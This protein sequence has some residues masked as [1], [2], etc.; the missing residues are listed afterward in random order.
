MSRQSRRRRRVRPTR[1]NWPARRRREVRRRRNR[2]FGIERF[3]PKIALTVTPTLVADINQTHL[4]GDPADFLIAGDVA[5]FTAFDPAHG[6]EL[7]KTD[8][9]SAGTSLVTDLTPGTASSGIAN[10]T[11]AGGKLF[12]TTSFN[13]DLWGPPTGK[14]LWTLDPATDTL[15]SLAEDVQTGYPGQAF[16]GILDDEFF[17]WRG[18]DQAATDDLWKT[19]G[20]VAGTSL[21]ASF[22]LAQAS[23]LQAAGGRLY[24]PAT[25]AELGEELYWTDGTGATLVKD[26]AAGEASSYADVLGVAGDTVLFRA[27]DGEIGTELWRTDPVEGAVLVA[28]LL[29]GSWS[30]NPFNLLVSGDQLF[31]LADDTDSQSRPRRIEDFLSSDPQVTTF[32]LEN[33]NEMLV[34][35]D[36]LYLA[37]DDGQVGNELWRVALN[38]GEPELVKNIFGPFVTEAFANVPGVPPITTETEPGNDSLA[39]AD[40]LRGSFVEVEPGVFEATVGLSAESDSSTDYFRFFLPA[41]YQLSIAAGTY[42]YADVY[43]A[44]GNSAGSMSYQPF[45]ASESGDYIVEVVTYSWLGAPESI[46]FRISV[47]D[48]GSFPGGFTAVGDTLYF[49]ANDREHGLEL[50][51]T[52]ATEGAVLVGDFYPGPGSSAPAGLTVVGTEVFFRANGNEIWKASEAAGAV[53]LATVGPENEEPLGSGSYAMFAVLDGK[54]LFADDDG[55]TG[56]ELW[57]TDTATGATGL[58]KEIA[59]GNEGAFGGSMS[60]GAAAALDGVLYF[61]ATDDTGTELWRTDGTEAGTR[62]V[63][64]IATTT[65][66]GYGGATEDSSS[67]G[68]LTPVGDLLFFTASTRESGRELW[69]TDGT[70]AG[71]VQVAEINPGASN[72]YPFAGYGS[73]A[74]SLT[75]AGSMLYFTANDGDGYYRLWKTDGE[76]TERVTEVDSWVEAMAAV[77]G[78]LFFTASD[79][80]AGFE[81]RRLDLATGSVEVFDFNPGPGDSGVFELLVFGDSLLF[82]VWA[83]LSNELW[84]FVPAAGDLPAGRELVGSFASMGFLGA[85]GAAEF[86]GLLYFSADDGESGSELWK[87]DGT[88]AGTEL[89]TDIF[90][91]LYS[92][93]AGVAN[94]SSPRGLTVSGGKLF[95]MAEDAEG[96]RLFQTDGSAAGTEPVEFVGVPGFRALAALGSLNGSLLFQGDDGAIGAEL[97]AL[98]APAAVAPG[99]PIGLSAVAGDGQASLSWSAP[100]STGGSAITDYVVEYS[101][102]GGENWS[103]LDDDVAPTTSVTVTSLTNGVS[104]VFRVAAVNAVGTGQAA[105]SPAVTPEALT[106][107]ESKGDVTLGSDANGE[108][109][110][111]G[112]LVT[113]DS[114]PANY[115]GLVAGGWTPVAADVDGGQNTVVLRHASGALYFIRLDDS[116]VQTGADSWTPAGTPEFFAAETFFGVDFDGDQVVGTALTVLESAG[117]ISLIVDSLGNLWAGDS[118]ITAVDN[119][120]NDQAL[121]AAGWTALAADVDAGTNTVVL[122][123]DSGA[124]YFLRLDASW[125]QVG[126]DS[127]TPA[128]T[129][130][131]FAAETRFGVD[132]DDD[133]VIGVALTAIESA[134]SVVLAVDSGGNLWAGDSPITTSGNPYN[135][136]A[137]LAAGWTAMAADVDAG[138]NTVVLKHSSGALY[139]LRMDEAWDQVGGDNWTPAGTPEFF[140][141]ETRFGVDFDGDRIIGVALT[142]LESAGSVALAMDSGGNLWAG[143]TPITANGIHYNFQALVAAGWT[144]MAADIDGGVNTLVI[145]HASGA[146]YFLRMD[147]FWAQ[148]GGDS[149]TPAGT[150]EFAAAEIRFGVDFDGDGE[151]GG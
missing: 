63:A 133:N 144:A 29:P 56:Q 132:F 14:T 2:L 143:S 92:E 81:L 104:Y 125:I 89:V 9:T 97:W 114:G 141:A 149:W 129:P 103:A 64:N 34:V 73:Y 21:V 151:I 51:R 105:V 37:A 80:E 70:A 42:A 40:D 69:K 15:V 124:L 61:A 98:A 11:L 53:K 96:V 119:Q 27:S 118:P 26:I 106:V 108:L 66:F 83:D 122:K 54:L 130:E 102:D 142:T 94:S 8:G 131:F 139:F 91:G 31:L 121:A 86:G 19:D 24:F 35:G 16:G 6:R 84:R 30:S 93:D 85:G 28:D 127:W 49:V 95:F 78:G 71:T 50:W 5:Y 110:A 128:G 22:A 137:L 23:P 18:D 123:H 113:F 38:G 4:A 90:P 47:G 59:A 72:N 117:S 41:G 146:L 82:T 45:L 32:Y 65:S 107:I 100:A 116:W 3:E 43:A 112:T 13:G 44:D 109:R 115:Q 39:Q 77:D 136:A 55:T 145:K 134:G 75:A 147:E 88:A 111:N 120:Y 52:D 33:V 7:W 17:F 48:G 25:T 1:S 10:L 68:S 150:P 135:S 101:A 79:P 46:T 60:Y 58:L 148:I 99:A 126:S 87:T 138:T 140:A 76:T 74:S 67:P 12:F 62:Q 20:T 57:A 36:F